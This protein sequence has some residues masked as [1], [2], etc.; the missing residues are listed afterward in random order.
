MLPSYL[1]T[2]VDLLR[3]ALRAHGVPIATLETDDL[4][5]G[6]QDPTLREAVVPMPWPFSGDR[7]T[8]AF[9]PTMFRFRMD[10][11]ERG[12]IWFPPNI[13][14]GERPREDWEETGRQFANAMRAKFPP[15]TPHRG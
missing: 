12:A 14:D 4:W 5:A 6:Q 3:V 13:T 11:G 15:P 8:V 7:I 9:Y 1:A 2:P 10:D